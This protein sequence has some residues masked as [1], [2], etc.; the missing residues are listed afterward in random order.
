VYY[1]VGHGGI[2]T[3]D[4]NTLKLGTKIVPAPCGDTR[5]LAVNQATGDL[6]VTGT[7]GLFRISKP[8]SPTP[9]VTQLATANLDGL[10]VT[11]D[12]K[13]IWAANLDIGG[14]TE[15]S[16][17][18]KVIVS[19]AVPGGA[20]G[21]AIASAAATHGV[22]GNLFV[23]SNDGSITM[24]DT[25]KQNALTVVAAGGS[26]GDFVTVGVDGFLYATQTDRVEQVQPAIFVPV[27]PPSSSSSPSP[28]SSTNTTTASTTTASTTT[29]SP[30]TM[31]TATTVPTPTGST[32]AVTTLA[33]TG[34]RSVGPLLAVG[35]LGIAAGCLLVLLTRRRSR[36]S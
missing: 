17:T 8:S 31:V 13:A 32:P 33:S 35:A 34:A 4:P 12:G 19:V 21:V 23:N 7:C 28:T 16:I 15:Y 26:R 14:V 25:H 3:F 5:G 27:G 20:D 11:P 18:G 29:T 24:V 6:L 22:A 36:R 9:V 30:A 10:T 1:G 2:Y